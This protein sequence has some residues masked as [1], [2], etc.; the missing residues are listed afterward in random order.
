MRDLM[1]YTETVAR[2]L[3]E[4]SFGRHTDGEFQTFPAAWQGRFGWN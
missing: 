1:Y 4:S 3:R 2:H